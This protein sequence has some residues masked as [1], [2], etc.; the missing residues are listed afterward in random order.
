[1]GVFKAKE[2]MIPKVLVWPASFHPLVEGIQHALR[3]DGAFRPVPA[4]GKG[5]SRLFSS[6]AAWHCH[7]FVFA[8]TCHHAS[9]FLRPLAPQAL[10]RFL[11]TTGALTP[12]RAAF[13]RPSAVQVSLV[14]PARPSPH[15]ATNHLAHSIIAFPLPDQRDGLPRRRLRLAPCGDHHRGLCKPL[16]D[17]QRVSF[18]VSRPGLRHCLTGSSQRP[19]ESC[20]SSCGLQIRLRLLPTPPHGDAVAFGYWE[21]ASP[22]GGL[23]PP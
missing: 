10:R 18:P 12:A 4:R 5:L 9:T 2:P 11:A 21:R 15:S 13:G 3:P 16:A 1:M 17:A 8:R 23:S 14:H 19:A 22:R 7:G 20:S 6:T